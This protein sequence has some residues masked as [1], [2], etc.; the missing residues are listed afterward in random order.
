M[1]VACATCSSGSE[2]QQIVAREPNKRASRRQLACIIVACGRVNSA[3]RRYS[4][5]PMIHLPNNRIACLTFALLFMSCHA[6]PSPNTAP[7]SPKQSPNARQE[8]P[9]TPVAQE[10]ER[11]GYHAKESFLEAPT[12]WEASTFRMRSKRS[13]SFRANQPQ[14]GTGN[15]FVRFWFFEGTYDSIEDA[16]NRLANLHLRSPEADA[17]V[18]EYDRVMRSGFR[19][20]TTVYFRQTDAIIFWDETRSFARELVKA[21]QG[22][23]LTL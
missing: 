7:P 17:Q 22:V 3:V 8:S 10:V 18:N 16:R 14:G 13:V 15:Y 1:S 23:D 20:G 5:L 12:P 11:R 2:T 19:V 4:C 21:T 9:L 6:K